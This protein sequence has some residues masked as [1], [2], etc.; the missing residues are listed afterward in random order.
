MLFSLIIAA[1][2]IEDYI[3]KCLESCASQIN[4]AKDEYEI[5]VVNDGSSDDTLLKIEAIT[6]K[7]NNIKVVTRLNGGLS[8]ARN[9]GLEVAKGEYVWFIDGDDFISNDALSKIRSHLY[10]IK[11]DAFIINYFEFFNDWDEIKSFS[12]NLSYHIEPQNHMVKNGLLP[13]MAWLTIHKRSVLINNSLKFTEGIIH[14]DLDFS[15]RSFTIYDNVYYINENLYYY[16]KNRL[17]SIMNDGSRK[18]KSLKSYIR[19]NEVWNDFISKFN[20]SPELTKMALGIIANFILINPESS[21]IIKKSKSYYYKNLWRSSLKNKI[22]T[23]IILFF[24]SKIY[25]KFL[26][27]Y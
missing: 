4:I 13:M 11:P 23:L 14:E 2:N 20:L 3:E 19:I 17:G 7:H 22:K 1:Y 5:I 24:P 10:K 18:L 21:K 15:F 27:H 25:S 16:R 6:E 9:S 8:A 12:F 26:S